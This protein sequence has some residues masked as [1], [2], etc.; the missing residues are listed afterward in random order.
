MSSP[1]TETQTAVQWL[2]EHLVESANQRINERIRYRGQAAVDRLYRMHSGPSGICHCGS[3]SLNHPTI[4]DH[5]AADIPI[6]KAF[7]VETPA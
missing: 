5:P 1:A 4:G 2:A 3:S 6:D 7:A